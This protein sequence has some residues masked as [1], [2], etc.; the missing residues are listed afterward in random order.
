MTDLHT[1]SHESW[2]Q[3]R[4]RMLDETSRFIEWG[5][6]H[7]ELVIEIP[8]RPAGEGGFPR[9]VAEWFW[10]VVL[11]SRPTEAIRRWRQRL[12]GRPAGILRRGRARLLR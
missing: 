6:A 12:R 4:Q 3:F 8:A 10:T 2:Q 9:Q 7:P 5:L 1:A 11:T